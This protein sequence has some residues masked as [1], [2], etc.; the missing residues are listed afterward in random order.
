[1]SDKKH[2]VGVD[3]TFA[4]LSE[5]NEEFR[6]SIE[7]EELGLGTNVLF[8]HGDQLSM[9]TGQIPPG[10]VT[11][12]Y[13]KQWIRD[14]HDTGLWFSIGPYERLDGVGTFKA[15]LFGEIGNRGSGDVLYTDI[16]DYTSGKTYGAMT[17]PLSDFPTNSA[18]FRIRYPAV[19]IESGHR[20]ETRVR[21]LGAANVSIYSLRWEVN[22]L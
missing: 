7:P 4:I 12:P 5:D 6:M 9:Q 18:G 2:D 11:D 8:W 10:Y 19:T 3:E 22:T 13:F 21:C 17:F 14:R 1:M 15:K 20:Y 16:Y